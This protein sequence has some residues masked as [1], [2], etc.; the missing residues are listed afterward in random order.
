MRRNSFFAP[1][2]YIHLGISSSRKKN[3]S[4][5]PLF[6]RISFIGIGAFEER[7][8]NEAYNLLKYVKTK[9]ARTLLGV[10]KVTQDNNPDTWANVPLQDFTFKSDIDW[11]QPISDIDNQLYRKYNLSEEEIA[12]IESMIKPME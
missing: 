10:L 9:F 7:E 4:S 2:A 6:S 11:N 1:L 3:L 8:V 12:F 5:T